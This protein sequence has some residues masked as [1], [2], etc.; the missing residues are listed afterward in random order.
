M[1]N[2]TFSQEQLNAFIDGEMSAREAAVFSKQ[3]AVDPQ[4]AGQV[5]VLS[6]LKAAVHEC[7]SHEPPCELP[8]IERL[9]ASRRK[10]LTV[11]RFRRAGLAL[12]GFAGVM[13]A[14]IVAAMIFLAPAP[15]TTATLLAK[16]SKQHARWLQQSS[17]TSPAL[18]LVRANAKLQFG[19]NFLVPDLSATG[20]RIATVER[21]GQAGMHVGYRGVH[22]CHLSLFANP[23]TNRQ[24]ADFVEI[25]HKR[26]VFY[27]W[28]T[29]GLNYLVL[30]VGM[31][32][33][34]LHL[35]ARD[36]YR[37]STKLK[38]FDKSMLTALRLNHQAS[39]PCAA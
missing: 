6:S 27:V 26:E 22:G 20:L 30:G 37:S 15:A 10:R 16:A 33:R 4:L 18:Q 14:S 17:N 9:L 31:D 21:F 2:E 28:R 8:D 36:I 35:V 24:P 7:S 13:A 25:K 34:R 3:M 5:A 1:T 19:N 32:Q 39:K 11:P 23:S 29:H 12:A 38:L